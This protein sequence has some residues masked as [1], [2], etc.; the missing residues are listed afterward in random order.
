MHLG[1]LKAIIN[2]L[3][4]LFSCDLQVPETLGV[5]WLHSSELQQPPWSHQVRF[6]RSYRSHISASTAGAPTGAA[7][8]Y[9]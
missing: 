2:T 4:N 6:T 9:I 1:A 8:C 5:T 7:G 3:G